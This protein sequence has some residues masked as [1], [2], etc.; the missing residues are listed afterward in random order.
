MTLFRA[1][2]SEGYVMDELTNYIGGQWVRSQ[3][4]DVIEA[5]DPATE[6]VLALLPAG[7]DADADAA[8][9]AA[10]TA[11]RHWAS[12][13]LDDRLTRLEAMAEAIDFVADELAELEHREM[14]KPVAL[15]R[16]FIDAGLAAFR[17]GLADAR[18]YDFVEASTVHADGRSYVVHKP[19]GVVAKIVP[20][21]VPI[22]Q[23]LLGL[24]AILAAGNTVVIKPSEKSSLS[25]RR[26]FDAIDLP[27]G[28]I[29]LVLGDRRAG[30]PL[31]SHPDIA[32][33]HFTG[34]VTVGRSVAATAARKLH[35][36]VLELG[37][38][39]AAIVDADVSITATAAA[40]AAGCF[41][42][43]GQICNSIER[44]YVHRSVF[45]DFAAALAAE[46]QT[47]T[48]GL[49]PLV[50][51]RQR[52]V[53]ARH[54]DDAVGSGARILTG[55]SAPSRPG[56]FYPAT[57]LVDVPT[58]CLLMREETFGPVAP[59]I[60][61]NSFD[62]A[63][64][65]AADTEFG[66]SGTLFSNDAG[67]VQRAGTLEVG[68]LWVNKWQ[69]GSANRCYEPAG[70]SGVGAAGGRAAFDASTRPSTIF[71]AAP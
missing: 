70:I 62:E 11:Q 25:A 7:C 66:L 45:E 2:Q 24:A 14:G 38:N 4:G 69:G 50:D 17:E 8:V 41:V 54:V 3:S 39:D 1:E 53:V 21:N 44:I 36:T 43:T 67:H 55:G 58:D 48:A 60:P 16:N 12:I 27:T 47:M 59:L 63:L 31:A 32:L 22:A 18:A 35:R 49:G 52:N 57:V 30:E 40:V 20:W 28:V 71:I 6:K 33:V 29:N 56:F 5:V 10:K 64:A 61:F 46:A 34:S 51:E 26:M 23:T 65:L 42:N 15:A 13:S 19:V 68:V 37:G 9:R